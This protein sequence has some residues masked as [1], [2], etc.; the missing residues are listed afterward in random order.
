M[1]IDPEHWLYKHTPREWIRAALSELERAKGALDAHDRK[2]ALA[3]C[4]RAAGMAIN[5]M[6][7]LDVRSIEVY[8]RSYMDHLVAL[9]NDVEAPIAVRESAKLLAEMPMPGSDVVLLRT[10]STD[11]KMLDAARDVM[12]HAYAMVLKHEPEVPD[13]T[14]T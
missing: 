3:V 8:G 10:A 4:R 9:S 12:A 7:A 13:P 5:G 1:K 2:G 11:R 6:L 14:Q